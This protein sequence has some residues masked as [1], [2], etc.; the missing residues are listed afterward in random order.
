MP[1]RALR[2]RIG[3]HSPRAR[4]EI[5]LS[6]P[7]CTNSDRESRRP[8]PFQVISPAAGPILAVAARL[9]GVPTLLLPL[10]E[11]R[12]KKAPSYYLW[13]QQRSP[14]LPSN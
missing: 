11:K 3:D 9:A 4:H 5:N 12:E 13:R 1:Y 6:P 14:D 2:R 8:S 7:C 10:R